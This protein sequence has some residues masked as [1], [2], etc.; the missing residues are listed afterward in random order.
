[1]K[2]SDETVL[3]FET[4][5]GSTYEINHGKIRRLNPVYEKRG[6]GNWYTLYN[7]PEIEVGQSAYLMMESLSHL[8]ADDYGQEGGDAMTTRIT[9]E[10]V[11][12]DVL[13]EDGVAW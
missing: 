12:I 6:D 11:G 13:N 10:V 3:V 8:G 4:Y 1:M 2:V 7:R 5:S 9:S